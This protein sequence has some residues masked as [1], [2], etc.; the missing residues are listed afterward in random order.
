MSVS[1]PKTSNLRM[2]PPLC[3]F[4]LGDLYGTVNRELLGFIETVSYMIP[5]EATWETDNTRKFMKGKGSDASSIEGG[6]DDYIAFPHGGSRVPKYI[7]ATIAFRVLHQEVPSIDTKF[8][9]YDG[10]SNEEETE[11]NRRVD[12]LE[13]AAQGAY[14][15]NPNNQ[16]LNIT[17]FNDETKNR[18]A[19]PFS[20]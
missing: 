15:D 7:L 10:S 2:K 4:R 20:D 1:S 5:E 14:R 12:M 3:K 13:L 11:E 6:T 18:N 17:D 8:Y 19:F 16:Q 9:G